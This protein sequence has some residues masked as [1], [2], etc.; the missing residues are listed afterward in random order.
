MG[1]TWKDWETYPLGRTSG[2][3]TVTKAIS[4]IMANQPLKSL[5]EFERNLIIL[6]K[7]PYIIILK[8]RLLR[9]GKEGQ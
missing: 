3:F 5:E 2:S 7:C 6:L 8:C 4:Y 1:S 9:H